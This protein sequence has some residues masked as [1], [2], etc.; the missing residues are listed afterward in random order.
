MRNRALQTNLIFF[1]ET[2]T[3]QKTQCNRHCVTC[4]SG[5]ALIRWRYDVVKDKIKYETHPYLN[6]DEEDIWKD[7]LLLSS[8]VFYCMI[9]V[10]M[11]HLIFR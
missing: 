1:L 3:I 2:L 8:S 11:V 7:N 10:T 9:W 5:I 4:P 6:D